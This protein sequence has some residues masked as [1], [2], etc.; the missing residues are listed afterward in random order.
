MQHTDEL[1]AAFLEEMHGLENFRMT[2]TGVHEAVTLEREDPEVKR[3]I[4]ALAFF[5]ARTRSMALEGILKTRRRIFQ[6]FFSFLVSPLPAMGILQANITGRFVEPVTL[7][8]G[9]AVAVTTEDGKAAVMGTI[10]DLRILPIRVEGLETLLLPGAGMRMV[11]S[12]KAGFARNDEVGLL[13][14]LVNH[15]NDYPASLVVLHNLRKHVERVSVVWNDKVSEVTQGEPCEVTWGAPSDSDG[16]PTSPHPLQKVRLFLHYPQREL[17]M[18]VRLPDAPR[19]WKRF[20]LVFDVGASWPKSLRLNQEMFQLFCV[21]I[22]NM[23]AG[24]AEMITADGAQ[25][26]Y[27]I[28]HPEPARGFSLHSVLGVYEARKQET[29]TLRPGIVS[30]GS[31]SFEVERNAGNGRDEAWL[32]LNFPEAVEKEKSII[33]EAM[34][35]QRWLSERLTQRLA[36]GLSDR[37]ISG[38]E[39]ELLGEI[40]PHVENKLVNDLDG[41]LQL[42]AMKSKA[43]LDIDDMNAVLGALG[44]LQWSVFKT[45]PALL[46]GLEVT[47]APRPREKGGG[48]KHTYRFTLKGF[49]APRRPLVEAF[50]Q[51][52]QR[53][54]T[55]WVPDGVVAVEGVLPGDEEPIAF[56]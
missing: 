35:Y 18:N 12:I 33:V 29:I 17:Y 10:F 4:E 32:K 3:L 44:T 11:L 34:W 47:S 24:M 31:G 16:H 48:L 53:L 51:Q 6:Q 9:S 13:P 40:R 1:Y 43:K 49:D 27:P 52:L 15:L 55:S 50:L 28:R 8:E 23:R 37:S 56:G 7:P 2:Y 30:G 39:F 5:N 38:V 20:S 19:N 14:I 42:L 36:V 22:V 26:R 45:I 46:D 41:M 21:P 54:L 25:E